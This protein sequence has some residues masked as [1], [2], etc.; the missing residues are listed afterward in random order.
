[1]PKPTVAEFRQVRLCEAVFADTDDSIIESALSEAYEDLGIKPKRHCIFAAGHLLA[2]DDDDIASMNG[3]A[4]RAVDQ[5]TAG[6]VV[7]DSMVAGKRVTLR[8]GVGQFPGTQEG[9]QSD[10][11]WHAT[12]FGRRYLALVRRRA[13]R[14]PILVV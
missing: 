5:G 9:Y 3:D 4:T 12:V 6:G 14:N 8:T 10:V 1:M 7:S 13:Y 2:K 11:D